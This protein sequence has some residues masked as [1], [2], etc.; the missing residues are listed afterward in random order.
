MDKFSYLSRGLALAAA[1]FFCVAPAMAAEAPAVRVGVLKFGTVNWE[2]DVIRHHELDRKNG[3]R[4]QTVETAGRDGS[5]IALQGGAVDV[6]VTDWIWVSYRRRSGADFAFVPHSHTVGGVM[7]RPDANVRTLEDLKGKRIGVGGGPVDKSWLLLRAYGMR[8]LGVDLAKAAEPV[9][10]APPLV[11]QLM[12]KGDLPVALNFWH[13]NARLAAA[14]MTQ[15][16]AIS[17]VLPALGVEGNP[18]L[19]GW[20]FSSAWGG[21]NPAALNGFL[22]ASADA[23]RILKDSDAE[24]ARIR[25]LTQAEDDSVF[26]ALRDAYRRGISGEESVNEAAASAVLRVL[27][28]FGDADAVGSRQGVAPGTFWR[29][30]GS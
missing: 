20:V 12:L 19:L 25:P 27:S 15:F 23:K 28:E 22:R 2:I 29:A 30:G 7:T 17:D 4:L 26:I 8:K 21:K 1:A 24:W 5:A 13:Y 14:G 10:G 6:I 18:P 3:F 9:Y 11:N 16:L